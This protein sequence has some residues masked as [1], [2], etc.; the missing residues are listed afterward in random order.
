MF[1]DSCGNQLSAGQKFCSSC[2]K[3]LGI[4]VAADAPRMAAR[5]RVR[6]HFHLLG[7]LWVVYS[8]I[9]VIVGVVMLIIANTLFLRMNESGFTPGMPGRVNF[10]Q[11]LL[12]AIGI[13]ILI[14][15]GVGIAAGVGLMQRQSW[16]RVLTLIL[17][18]ISLIHIPF[19]TALGIYSIWVLLAPN[20]DEDYQAMT[21]AATA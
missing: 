4:P 20:A 12:S 14:K 9:T 18:F 5:N 19:G 6:E 2:G 10:L 17:G 1:C 15:A 13:A 11:P 21:R 7:I 8:A 16:A 3:P